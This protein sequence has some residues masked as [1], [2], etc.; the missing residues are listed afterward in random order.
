MVTKFRTRLT[1]A[2]S[3]AGRAR[4]YVGAR[5]KRFVFL[6]FVVAHVA[7]ALTSIEAIMQRRTPQGAV[8]WAVSLNAIPVVAVPLYW[9]VGSIDLEG[10]ETKRHHSRSQASP[11]V[12]AAVDKARAG[13]A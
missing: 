2:R 4:R 5:R 9:L 6:F 1:S 13:G 8:A 12:N 3:R 7:G 11:L 10:Y